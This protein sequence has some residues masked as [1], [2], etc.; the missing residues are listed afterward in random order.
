M[1]LSGGKGSDEKI[2]EAEAMK[3]YCIDKGIPSKDLIKEDK[4]KTTLE[5]LKNSKAII[6][7]RSGDK[8]AVLVTSNYHVYRSLR[9]CKKNKTKM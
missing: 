2:S 6:N 5:N 1:I 9:Y 7:R 3:R 8:N 4:S